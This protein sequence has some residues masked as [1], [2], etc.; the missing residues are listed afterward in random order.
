MEQNV[1]TE[2]LD[3]LAGLEDDQ[4][5][6]LLDSSKLGFDGNFTISAD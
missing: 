4:L 6:G 2:I 3:S 5:Q 1:W